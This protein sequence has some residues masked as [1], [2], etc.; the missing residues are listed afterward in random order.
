MNIENSVVLLTGANGGIGRAFVKELLARGAAKIYLGVR[1]PATVQD[2]VA[3]SDRLVAVELD[4]AHPDQ[5][6]AIAKTAGDINL[7]INNAGA[8]AF[9]GV[10]SATDTA[11]ART[12]MEVNYFGVLALS[13]AL[14]DT[15]AFRAGGAIV[16]ILSVLSHITLPVAGTYSASKA[17]ALHLT[18]TLRAELK[19]RGV[20]VL[21]VLPAQT[22]TALGAPL[23]E[24]K[25]T[26]QQVVS[27]ALDALAAGQD[28]VFPGELS[29]GT[30]KAFRDDP[31]GVQAHMAQLVHP[32]A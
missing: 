27:G 30:A 18:R 11:G 5:I 21:A 31:D 1:N 15:A 23:P 8:A 20:Q 14:R 12:E 6:A 24:P 22:D 17:A 32:I 2:L 28:E 4:L 25:L 19:Q 26:P 3:G 10:L 7:L 29:A 9:S 16:N 13:Q